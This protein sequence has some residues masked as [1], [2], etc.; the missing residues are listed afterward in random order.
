MKKKAIITI[1]GTIGA[2]DKHTKANYYFEGE[3]KEV[4]YFNTFPL[5][6]DKYSKEYEIVPIYT[7]IAK[8]INIKVL[9]K[10]DISFDKFD[11]KFLINDEKDFQQI[12]SIINTAI[13]SFD[14]LIIDVSHGFRHLPILMIVD[15]IIQNFQDTSKIQK[16]LFAK[17]IEQFKKYEI[18]DLKEYLDLSN[19]AFVLTTFEKNYTVANH[20]K[21]S[22]YKRLLKELNDFSN[23]IMALNIGNLEKTS[24]DLVFEL[25]KID[26][27]A[28]KRQAS[29]LKATIEKLV[30]FKDKK[31]YQTYY[32]LSK[33]LFE[34]DYILL[35]LSLL[36]ESIRLYMKSYLK[37]KHREIVQKVERKLNNNL[38][39]I[40]S[41]F[42]NLYRK[43]KGHNYK[44]HI[45]LEDYEILHN[46]FQKKSYLMQVKNLSDEIDRKRNNLAHANSGQSYENI[47]SEVFKLI[48]RY[49]ALI[50]NK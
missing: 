36:C 31:R 23:D 4:E 34:K 19:I 35:S 25:N 5:L 42:K 29:N 44:R 49:E 12:F 16:I 11:N 43:H 28:I 17:E 15:L 30:N 41:F 9:E 1:L 27:I 8:D 48:L 18:I 46:Y 14:E 45:S 50:K 2:G 24:K 21:S 13:N 38:Y 6:I 10:S 20:I 3:E 7:Q 39:D 32:E 47:R 26:D 37:Q 33:N 40:G 22:K